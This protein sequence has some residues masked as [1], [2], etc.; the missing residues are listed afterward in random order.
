MNIKE[1]AERTG[2]SAHTIRFYEEKGLLPRVG[3]SAAGIRQFT[4]A[5]VNFLTFLVGL[6]KTGMSLAEMA[7]FTEDGCI[8]ERLQQGDIPKESVERRSDILQR[9]RE[10]LLDQQREI[11]FLLEVVEEK[12]KVYD[13]YMNA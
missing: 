6:K 12:L 9:H 3:R 8:L 11:A 4:D 5:D 13:Q 7:Q 1:V 2:L 10:R